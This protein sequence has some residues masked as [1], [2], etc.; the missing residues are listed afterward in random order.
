MKVSNTVQDKQ[1]SK[2]VKIRNASEGKPQSENDEDDEE[3]LICGE[4]F[5]AWTKWD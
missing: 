2:K 4:S 1:Q 5:S 3:C